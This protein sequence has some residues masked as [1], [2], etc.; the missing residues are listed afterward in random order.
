MQDTRERLRE[1]AGLL[2]RHGPD[3]DQARIYLDRHRFDAEFVAMAGHAR[4]LK[5]LLGQRDR[6]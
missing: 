6:N 5:K 1:Y 4:R 2:V 3:S